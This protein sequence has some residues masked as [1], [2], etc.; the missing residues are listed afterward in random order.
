MIGRN[1]LERMW[2]EAIIMQFKGLSWICLGGEESNE[3]PQTGQA[4]SGSGV[5]SGTP[6][7]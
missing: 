7:S 4:V 1:E 5:E 6:R 2:K 3:N